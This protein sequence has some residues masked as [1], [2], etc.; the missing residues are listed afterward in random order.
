MHKWQCPLVR[1]PCLHS[2]R[3]C[4]SIIP[5]SDLQ[6]HLSICPFEAFSGFLEMNDA[7]LKSLISRAESLEEELEHMREHLKRM[8]GNVEAM[9]NMRRETSDGWRW[10]EVGRMGLG[11]TPP[12][13]TPN[14]SDPQTPPIIYSSPPTPTPFH[15]SPP[16][17]ISSTSPNISILPAGGAR[18]D[19][20]PHHHRSIVA[21]SFGS[22]QSYAD[23]TFSR[24][25]GNAGNVGWEEVINGLR[26]LVIQLASGLDSMERRNEVCVHFLFYT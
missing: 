25:P 12:S 24:L 9:G 21:P 23:W 11:D 1:I 8:E 13:I 7:R 16:P 6:A 19:L 20:A 17:V 22:H 3:G 5:R 15:S 2:T 10:R 26:T 14:H 4:S 18:P